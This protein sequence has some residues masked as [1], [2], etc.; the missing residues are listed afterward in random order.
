MFFEYLQFKVE[1]KFNTW[2]LFVKGSVA[3]NWKA[4]TAFQ[5]HFFSAAY[6]KVRRGVAKAKGSI[7]VV[8]A[9]V[10]KLALRY[11]FYSIKTF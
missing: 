2:Q 7:R 11:R 3:N 1:W 6:I 4:R 9:N 8:R 5:V 10:W